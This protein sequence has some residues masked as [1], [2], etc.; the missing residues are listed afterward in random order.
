MRLDFDRA[1]AC[2]LKKQKPFKQQVCV[3]ARFSHL[4]PADRYY[5]EIDR[6]LLGSRAYAPLLAH[7]DSSPN[8]TLEGEALTDHVDHKVLKRLNNLV[9]GIDTMPIKVWLR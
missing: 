3:E 6:D 5:S 8:G 1:L 2:A 4:S 9:N 7:L